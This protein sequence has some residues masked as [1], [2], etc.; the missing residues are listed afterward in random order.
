MNHSWPTSYKV[1]SNLFMQLSCIF[2]YKVNI[3]LDVTQVNSIFKSGGV[4]RFPANI[5]NSSNESLEFKAPVDARPTGAL[6]AQDNVSFQTI[7]R[8]CTGLGYS[9]DSHSNAFNAV[10][11][12]KGS[13]WAD[14][15]DQQQFDNKTKESR[16]FLKK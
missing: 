11:D 2:I 14:I 12:F 1:T 10:E 13:G 9:G 4:G 5:R 6:A 16:F 3:M 8:A 7:Q 15:F